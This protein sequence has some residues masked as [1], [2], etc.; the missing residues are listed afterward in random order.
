MGVSILSAIYLGL[1]FCFV[2]STMLRSEIGI[3][4]DR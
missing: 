1:S 2:L 4:G 3:R